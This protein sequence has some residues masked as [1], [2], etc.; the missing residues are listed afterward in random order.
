MKHVLGV[1]D[2]AVMRE[3]IARSLMARGYEVSMSRSGADALR[4]LRVH[5]TAIVVTDIR[6]PV[7]DGFSFAR[8]LRREAGMG[9]PDIIF[10]SSLDERDQYRQAMHVG[11]ADFLVKPFK[12]QEIVDAVARCL[13]A[14]DRRS[15]A[16]EHLAGDIA[17]ENMPRIPGYKLLQKL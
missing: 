17:A 11:A 3:Y 13:E 16:A 14:R 15:K 12:P 2:D 4:Q 5:P 6:M 7:M 9:Q 1:E 10:V 8:A